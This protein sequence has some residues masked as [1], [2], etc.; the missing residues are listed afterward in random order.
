MGKGNRNRESR[1]H[2]REPGVTNE[3]WRTIRREVNK[4][5]LKADREYSGNFAAGVLWALHT[6]FGFGPVRLRR[7]WDEYRKLHDQL[8]EYY[9]LTDDQD[10]CYLCRQ[11]LKDYGIDIDEWERE[12]SVK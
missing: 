5:I 3:Q 9:E 1:S 10:T 7:M 12:G 6:T 8:R 4:A 2:K 11:R